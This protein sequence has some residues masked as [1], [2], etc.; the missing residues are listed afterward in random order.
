MKKGVVFLV[1]MFMCI[2]FQ[3][4]SQDSAVIVQNF[5]GEGTYNIMRETVYDCESLTLS[6]MIIERDVSDVQINRFAT[7][8]DMGIYKDV[9]EGDF[10]LFNAYTEPV[11]EEYPNFNYGGF[12]PLF[13]S[14]FHPERDTVIQ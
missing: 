7:R 10:L 3:C 4:T 2:A 12:S 6:K 9:Q 1:G 5:M 11:L 13:W 14:D 8:K